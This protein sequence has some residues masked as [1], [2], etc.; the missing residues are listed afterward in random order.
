GRV[1]QIGSNARLDGPTGKYVYLGVGRTKEHQDEAGIF[2]QDS[3]RLKPTLTL[4]GGL[5]WQL[6]MPFQADNSVYSMNTMQDLCGISGLGS[7]PGGRECNLFNP[8]VFN[9]GGRTPI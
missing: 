4:N 1:T 5:R 7:G 9:A 6:A 2:V 8:G 3:W